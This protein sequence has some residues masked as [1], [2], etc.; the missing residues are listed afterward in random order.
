MTDH[1]D[2]PT[3]QLNPDF[4]LTI[5]TKTIGSDVHTT[6]SGIDVDGNKVKVVTVTR[7]GE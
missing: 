1:E 5:E 3:V 2:K 6:V 7:G 4:P